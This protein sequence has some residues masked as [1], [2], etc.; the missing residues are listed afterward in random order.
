MF[1]LFLVIIGVSVFLSFKL[2]KPSFLAA[3]I[4]ALVVFIIIQIAMVPLGFFE[5]VKFIFSLR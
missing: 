2:K 4:G 5:T 1:Y 3:P